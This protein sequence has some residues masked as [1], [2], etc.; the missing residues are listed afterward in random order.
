MAYLFRFD[1]QS[2]TLQTVVR[3]VVSDASLLELNSVLEKV[4]VVRNPRLLW[5]D[6]SAVT[7]IKVSKSAI[8]SL[9]TAPSKI[10]PDVLRVHIAPQDHAY[11][12]TRMFQILAGERRPK[13]FV[14]RTNQE[15]QQLLG[16]GES[17]WQNVSGF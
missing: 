6:W 3:G 17:N 16:V 12:L 4:W 8:R 13:I 10:P 2:R 1:D 7:E 5:F 14:V 11:G 15:A 9:A